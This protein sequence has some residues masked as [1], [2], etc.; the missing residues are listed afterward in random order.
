MKQY[1]SKIPADLLQGK[2]KAERWL[3]EQADVGRQQNEDLHAQGETVLL[4]LAENNDRLTAHAAKDEE[5]QGAIKKDLSIVNEK[6]KKFTDPKWVI[7]SIVTM[8]VPIVG[9]PIL[10]ELIKHYFLSK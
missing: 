4:R 5:I 6:M 2:S 10:I 3:Y 9:V 7:G 1:T 8:L